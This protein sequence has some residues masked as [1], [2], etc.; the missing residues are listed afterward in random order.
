MWVHNLLI[1]DSHLKPHRHIP[2]LYRTLLE[3]NSEH[4]KFWGTLHALEEYKFRG[5]T[6]DFIMNEL[7]QFKDPTLIILSIGSNDIRENPGKT[8]TTRLYKDLRSLLEELARFMNLGIVV[9]SPI[10]DLRQETRRTTRDVTVGWG[11]LCGER[12]PWV[13]FVDST[14][15]LRRGVDDH[16]LDEK[17]FE[18]DGY[19]LNIEGARIMAKAIHTRVIN[20]PTR[21]FGRGPNSARS[22]RRAIEHNGPPE[23][24]AGDMRHELDQRQKFGLTKAQDPP[25]PRYE[26]VPEEDYRYLKEQKPKPKRKNGKPRNRGAARRRGEEKSKPVIRPPPAAQGAFRWPKKKK[27]QKLVS[28]R[29]KAGKKVK[30]EVHKVVK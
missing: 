14:E 12:W 2:Y 30:S 25:P 5:D 26:G 23:I 8:T 3:A 6:S 19:H 11:Q 24:Y 27:G 21:V 22:T 16:E 7:F 9:L 28:R 13:A 15:C 4:H 18:E 10:P 17:F 29:A 20:F 1:G